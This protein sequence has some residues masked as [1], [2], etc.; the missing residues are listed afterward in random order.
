MDVNGLKYSFRYDQMLNCEGIIDE[1]LTTNIKD[2]YVNQSVIPSCCVSYEINW[3]DL[4]TEEIFCSKNQSEMKCIAE[5]EIFKKSLM[6]KCIS[7]GVSEFFRVLSKFDFDINHWLAKA[8]SLDKIRFFNVF[9][10]LKDY[11]ILNFRNNNHFSPIRKYLDLFSKFMI[12]Y[13]PL[14]EKHGKHIKNIYNKNKPKTDVDNSDKMTTL[15]DDIYNKVIEN[16][17]SQSLNELSEALKEV[18]KR[19]VFEFDKFFDILLDKGKNI[20]L[21]LFKSFV[22]KHKNMKEEE[23]LSKVSTSLIKFLEEYNKAI[24]DPENPGN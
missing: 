6:D 24:V 1:K 17:T 4:Q 11:K 8:S 20:D 13:Y 21:N 7:V 14:L 9:R 19:T 18:V 5:I 3:F 2:N 12:H 16:L 23:F 10:V 15:K 22:G